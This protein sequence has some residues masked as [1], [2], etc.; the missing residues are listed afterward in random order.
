NAGVPV[1]SLQP[2]ASAQ[3]ESGVLKSMELAPVTQALQHGLVPVL[4]GD[5]A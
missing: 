5:V 4:Y 2:S 1:W 3:C